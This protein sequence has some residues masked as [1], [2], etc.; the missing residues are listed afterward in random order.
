MLPGVSII[1]PAYNAEKTI[2]ECLRA[3]QNLDWDGDREVILVN[4]GSEDN[5]AQIASA[6]P[7]VRVI[8]TPNGG[9]PRATNVG[10]KAARYDVVVSV[11]SDAMLEK[12]WLRKIMPWF[13]DTSVAAVGGHAVTGNKHL[14]GRIAG[15]YS[16]MQRARCSTY[17]D[18]LG[19]VSTAYRRQALIQIGM[20]DEQMK[21]AYDVDISRRLKAA[22]YQL[23]LEKSA[24]CKHFWRDDLKSYCRQQYGFAYYRL[25]LTRKFKRAHDQI[26][27]LGMI[28]QVPFT[29]LV[30]LAAVSG[31][32]LTPLVLLV[33]VLLP[34]VHMGESAAILSKKKDLAAALALPFLFTLRNFAWMY[35]ATI[36]GLRRVFSQIF[37]L[38]YMV[39]RL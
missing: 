6:F 8:N 5:T 13:K 12:E 25:E 1:I 15:Y 27:G 28:L 31:S 35:A 14:L 29:A 38:F 19:T 20:F 16:E 30:I 34:L 39:R 9:A 18:I 11:D 26:S 10:I 37:A 23:V 33:L 21:I 7:Q 2:A 22:G 36:W 17:I 4:D 24:T 32:F 3:V